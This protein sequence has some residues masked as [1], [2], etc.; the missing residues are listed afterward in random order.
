VIRRKAQVVAA[1]QAGIITVEEVNERYSVSP[2]EFESW[3][4]LFERHGVYGLRST[5]SQLYRTGPTDK[6]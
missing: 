6:G 4:R 2:E 3:K 5:R 1:V